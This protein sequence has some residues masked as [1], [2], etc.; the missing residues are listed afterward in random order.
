MRKLSPSLAVAILLG[1]MVFMTANTLTA[2]CFQVYQKTILDTC[3]HQDL[4]DRIVCN[5]DAA[6]ELTAC[7]RRAIF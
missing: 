4:P 6:T 1:T 3:S 7:V 5:L 2:G